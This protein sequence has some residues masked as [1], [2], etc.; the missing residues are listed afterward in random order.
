MDRWIEIDCGKII[1]NIKKI[2]NFTK[3]KFMATVKSDFYG[4]GAKYVSKKIESV[5]DYF[6]VAIPSEGI[7]LR[8]I[9]I[10]KPIL[11]LGPILPSDVEELIM[12]DI[13][14]T[15]CSNDVF[16]QLKRVSKKRQKKAVVHIKIDTGMGRIGIQKEEAENF[17][18]KVKE[19]KNI[20]TKGIYTHLATAEWENKEYAKYQIESFYSVLEEI[21]KIKNIPLKHIANSAAI[22][23]LPETYKN[24]DMIRIGLLT[25]GIYP[26][27]ELYKRLKLQPALKG[28]C[29]VLF[30]KE[31]PE[32]RYLSYGI[33][34]KTEKKTK[35]A[36]LGIGYGDGLRRFL[37]NKFELKWNNKKIKIIG[38]I[39]MD[40][41]LVDVSGKNVK[42][43]DEIYIFGD[44]FEIEDM[45]KIGGTTPQE[46]LCGFGARRIQKVYK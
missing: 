46:I 8:E 22:I 23:N 14:I 5:V 45:A 25:L 32:G 21:N 33:T 39:C 13:E 9:G 26:A 38:N 7:E 24:F 19:E 2:K 35:V 41:T 43:G 20:F 37:S 28:F 11:V 40:Q 44:G 42:I 16:E 18:K 31:L 17:I 12:R 3:K 34:Y 29:K 1:E 4:M 30:L 15:L 27:K 36:T 10:K 6:G